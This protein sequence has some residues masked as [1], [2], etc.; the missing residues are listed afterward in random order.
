M[1]SKDRIRLHIN[2]LE[3]LENTVSTI[4]G[5]VINLLDTADIKRFSQYWVT[6]T[7]I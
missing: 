4:Y 1:I 6:R 5:D 2:E 3:T 7:D